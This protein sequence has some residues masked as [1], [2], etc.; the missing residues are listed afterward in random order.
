METT[1]Q[2]HPVAELFPLL[3]GDAFRSL[4]AD[5][6]ENGLRE[7]ILEDADGR[8]LDGRNR[9][10]ACL[11]AGVAPRF[12]RWLDEGSPAALAL[13]RN[14][15]RRHLNES[16][17]A[18]LAARLAALPAGGA[19]ANLQRRPDRTSCPAG[20]RWSTFLRGWCATP[21]TSC[22]AAPRN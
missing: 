7:P 14:L 1:R 20:P 5:I 10:L 3:T 13:S 18:L 2:F 17:R 21:P 12:V 11:Q 19:P 16:Q 8:I 6:K 9:Y 15:H 22:A 4:V